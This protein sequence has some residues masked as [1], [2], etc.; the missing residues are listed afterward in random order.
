MKKK[1]QNVNILLII[2]IPAVIFLG[3]LCY[4]RLFA[5]HTPPVITMDSDT[6]SVSVYDEEDALLAGVTAKDNRDGDLTSS[7]VVEKKTPIEDGRRTVTYAVIDSK[8]NVGRAE[9]SVTYIGYEG[10]VFNLTAPL[11]F[12]TYSESNL[13]AYVKAENI[14]DGDL[15]SKVKCTTSHAYLGGTIG[16]YEVEYSV[17]DSLG[18]KTC[19]LVHTEFYDS[20]TEV[21]SIE[22]SDYLIY[23][24][25]GDSFDPM[26]YYVSSDAGM[27][28]EI[29]S[30]V[31]T[32]TAGVYEVK[33][34]VGSDDAI[35][36]SRLVV[37]VT[38]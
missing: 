18:K 4:A 36:G 9:R 20:E 2:L 23:V 5:D 12:P 22:L 1:K 32:S 25:K 31:D 10:T 26:T 19:L 14:I 27:Y 37:V 24:K 33:Y 11:R 35:G 38:E 16:E 17:T 3:Y 34:T 21:Y 8:G 13:L 15:T 7:V 28:P 6:L 29:E 30:N